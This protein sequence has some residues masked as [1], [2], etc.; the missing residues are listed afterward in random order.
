MDQPENVTS[1][2]TATEVAQNKSRP[3]LPYPE[4]EEDIANLNQIAGHI[5]QAKFVI[6]IKQFIHPSQTKIHAMCNR[7]IH[8]MPFAEGDQIFN[9]SEPDPDL[10]EKAAQAAHS[11][12][13]TEEDE[14]WEQA[15]EE[16]KELFR[17]MVMATL[18]V[19]KK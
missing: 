3:P 2:N 9:G 4:F 5:E 17:K 19:F 13:K 14:P 16:D 12:V 10:I 7:V 1:F 8:A 6:G 15:P 11:A 18:S